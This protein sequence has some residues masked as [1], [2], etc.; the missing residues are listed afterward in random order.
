M[1]GVQHGKVASSSKAVSRIGQHEKP[2]L[3]VRLVASLT[4]NTLRVPGKWLEQGV[5]PDSWKRDKEVLHNSQGLA[6]T[7][8]ESGSSTRA[9]PSRVEVQH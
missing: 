7:S 1:E 6:G 4:A 5:T 3:L 2:S 9:V 8:A